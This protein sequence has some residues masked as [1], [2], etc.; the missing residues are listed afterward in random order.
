MRLFM[1]IVL[2]PMC[3]WTIASICLLLPYPGA[4]DWEELLEKKRKETYVIECES[5]QRIY[6]II[7]LLSLLVMAAC[8]FLLVEYLLLKEESTIAEL[9]IT[10]WML[11]GIYIP[12]VVVNYL[13]FLQVAREFYFTA[14]GFWIDR[15]E[16]EPIK[17]ED[18]TV[19][20]TRITSGINIGDGRDLKIKFRIGSRTYVV[21]TECDDTEP[22]L[23]NE[24]KE[25]FN[26]LLEWLP[27]P[28][29]GDDPEWF[30]N[31]KLRVGVLMLA[32]G[33]MLTAVGGGSFLMCS[34]TG[35]GTHLDE[36]QISDKEQGWH[37]D[38]MDIRTDSDG[39][40]YEL[41]EDFAAV[42]VYGDNDEF[43]Y[44]YLFP[45]G[46]HGVISFTVDHDI[47]YVKNMEDV[48]YSY[49][50]DKYLG[51][52]EWGDLNKRIRGTMG[53]FSEPKYPYPGP[54]NTDTTSAAM[55]IGALMITLGVFVYKKSRTGIREIM[56]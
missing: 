55:L 26:A 20:R 44:A 8:C 56:N 41:L 34:G 12:A 39:N 24:T 30:E 47:V 40:R 49:K 17:Y 36:G 29:K 23:T 4:K 3:I 15:I 11:V 5:A 1:I 22:G 53:S 9:P 32:C 6:D 35:V 13:A 37:A 52:V 19:L 25:Q 31:L 46:E 27:E 33:I 51:E 18:I 48:I 10:W 43:L 54:I 45:K 16:G 21:K 50:G 14:D 38:I 2:V 28:R 42:N 7:R